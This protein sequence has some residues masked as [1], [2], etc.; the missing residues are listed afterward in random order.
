MS[1]NDDWVGSFEQ[2]ELNICVSADDKAPFSD[3]GNMPCNCKPSKEGE[4]TCLDDRCINFA[5]QTECVRCSPSCGN[6]R[7]QKRNFKQVLVKPTPGKG[8]GLF[9]CEKI[10]KGDL[11]IEY[12]GEVISAKELPIRMEKMNQRGEQHLYIMQLKAK[13]FVD[14]RYKGAISRFMN[15]SCE[16]NIRLEIWTVKGKLR[17]GII[18]QQEIPNECEI[19]ADYQWKPSSRQPTKCYCHTPLCRGFLEIFSSDEERSFYSRN[20]TWRNGLTKEYKP[21]SD[22]TTGGDGNLIILDTI[23][24][25]KG[26]II[27]LKMENKMVK[28]YDRELEDY[29][30]AKV[31]EYAPEMNSYRLLNFA[32]KIT[33]Y[34]NLDTLIENW[35]WLDES[36]VFNIKK[37]VLLLLF[38]VII[39]YVFC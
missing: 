10:S 21:S 33:F 24:D 32:N 35:Y 14:S 23:Y 29:M 7:F 39:I 5:T 8:R 37:K 34:E 17:L 36:A 30:T 20:G 9:A 22:T 25:T 1:A 26:K 4:V 19:T 2:V 27:P 38:S 15:H 31:I 18:A 12:V 16:P 6:N 13:T 11:I 28:I 3:E